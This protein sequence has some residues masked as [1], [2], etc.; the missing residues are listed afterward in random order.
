VAKI[1]QLTDAQRQFIREGAMSNAYGGMS[2]IFG[3][4][5]AFEKPFRYKFVQSGE[6]L[7]AF[8]IGEV[9][10][11]ETEGEWTLLVKRPTGDDAALYIVN[12]NATT[13]H[14][15]YG[16]GFFGFSNPVYA[17]YDDATTPAYG[18]EWGPQ[19]TSYEL[20]RG[21]AGFITVGVGTGGSTDRV[22]VIQQGKQ[23]T[24]FGTNSAS[25][26]AKG[27]TATVTMK[28]TSG[29]SFGFTRSVKCRLANLAASYDCHIAMID[30]VWEL[31]GKECE[32]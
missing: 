25:L 28:D 4:G 30:G 16:F 18:K 20:K 13:A 21:R 14:N 31:T 7:P 1:F 17:L 10:G 22:L 2:P 8:G 11:V 29:T 19:P 3:G 5:S 15:A 24:Y 23:G 6:T 12:Y 9:Y 32:A 27:G 26:V